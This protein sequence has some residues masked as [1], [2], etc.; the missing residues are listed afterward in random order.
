MTPFRNGRVIVVS[1]ILGALIAATSPGLARAA[2]KVEKATGD[3][4][5]P[6]IGI[7]TTP[8]IKA[9]FYFKSDPDKRIPLPLVRNVTGFAADAAQ[10]K[11][12]GGNWVY[13]PTTA[14]GGQDTYI[15]KGVILTPGNPPTLGP[16]VTATKAAASATGANATA[17]ASITP[18]FNLNGNNEITG[19]GGQTATS[20]GAT[21]KLGSIC[22]SQASAGTDPFVLAPLS[23]A[24]KVGLDVDLNPNYLSDPRSRFGLEAARTGLDA[25]SSAYGIT[26]QAITNI[27]NL[28]NLFTLGFS[29]DSQTDGVKVQFTSDDPTAVSPIRA[30]DFLTPDPTDY[31]G[32]Y[33]LDPSKSQFSAEFT[34]PAG[35]LGA[36]ENGSYG[37]SLDL[38]QGATASALAAVPEPGSLVIA[39]TSV[40]CLLGYSC[41]GRLAWFCLG[42]GPHGAVRPRVHAQ[43][44]IGAGL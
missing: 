6:L 7:I 15:S 18:S 28:T 21:A 14:T 25:G 23:S 17:S 9:R 22:S 3:A 40:L 27:P 32:L 1:I 43:A 26:Y 37:L 24:M 13:D 11:A 19:A 36:D 42:N 16:A 4:S 2:E 38:E 41:C 31:P 8:I 20:V 34:V 10:A 35:V 33:V 44:S 29:A 39:V 12:F 5:Y 30:T